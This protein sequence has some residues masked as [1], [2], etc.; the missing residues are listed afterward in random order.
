VVGVLTFGFVW[1]GQSDGGMAVDFDYIHAGARAVLHGESPYE[2]VR[3]M[4]KYP[5]YYPLTATIISAPFGALSKHLAVSLFTALGMALL[6]YSLAASNGASNGASKG[7]RQWIVLSPMAFQAVLFGQWSPWLTAGVGLP[8]LGLVWAAKPNIG[9]A[10]FA[11]YPSRKALWGILA[12]LV[13]SVLVMPS[14]PLSWYEAMQGTPQYIA[15]MMR[16]GGFLL[17]LAWLR[18]R[19]PEGRLLGVMAMVPH[20]TTF[21]E[22]VPLLL[23]PQTRGR[24]YWAFGLAWVV[25]LYLRFGVVGLPDPT[26]VQILDEVWPYV[27]VGLYLPALYF[28]LRQPSSVAAPRP[29]APSV[30]PLPSTAASEV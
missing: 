23:I 4:H 20:T 29:A 25:A 7:Y 10:L 16:P 15:P 19:T 2:A 12:I 28:V 9:L 30:P 6:C 21:Y 5:Y 13:A 27:L 24:F 18:W 3:G 11:A 1:A 22:L 17:L 8:W 14:W 26:P